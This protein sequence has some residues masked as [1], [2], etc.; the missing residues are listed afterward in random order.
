[1]SGRNAFRVL[2]AAAA[3]AG[4][5]CTYT[6]TGNIILAR[7]GGGWIFDTVELAAGWLAKEA[8]GLAQ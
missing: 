1:M 5:T 2:Q 3:W 8:E 7:V 6:I 4:F